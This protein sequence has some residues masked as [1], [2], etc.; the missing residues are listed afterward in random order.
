MCLN[1]NMCSVIESMNMKETPSY[2]AETL[3][4]WAVSQIDYC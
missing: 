2:Y 1:G 3:P 4:R